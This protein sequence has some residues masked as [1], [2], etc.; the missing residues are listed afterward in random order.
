MFTIVA[1]SLSLLINNLSALDPNTS[2]GDNFDLSHWKLLL[3]DASEEMN[4]TIFENEFF[5]TADDGSMLFYVRGEG[6]SELR[7]LCNS[8]SSTPERHNW[9]VTSG[10]HTVSGRY[11]IGK[12]DSSTSVIIQQIEAYNGPTLLQLKWTQDKLYAVVLKWSQEELLM[13]D[14]PRNETFL[15]KTTVNDGYLQLHLNGDIIHN[16]KVG[17]YWSGYKNYFKTGN[18]LESSASD[19]E[20][21]VYVYY[22]YVYQAGEC[23]YTVIASN[24]KDNTIFIIIAIVCVCLVCILCGFGFF[25]LY[26]YKNKHRG[27]RGKHSF[28]GGDKTVNE[29]MNTGD[30]RQTKKGSGYATKK[31][32]KIKVKMEN[33]LEMEETTR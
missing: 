27:G 33:T 19:S 14:V 11:K 17:D 20:A 29:E 8:I 15:V 28:D 3:P 7:Q 26:K 5:K 21:Y 25:F 32:K 12:I 4:L 10:I 13:G 23:S 9:P 6:G 30:K 16:F 31:K 1:I 18:Y 24:D 2:P 22:L